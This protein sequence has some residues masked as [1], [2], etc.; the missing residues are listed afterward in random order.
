[1]LYRYNKR[2]VATARRLR[3][4][5]TKEERHLWYDFL[6]KLPITVNRQKNIGDYIVDFFIAEKRIVIELDGAQ[7]GT[8]EG[9]E[10][11]ARR[12]AELSRLGL[13][14]LRYKNADIHQNFKDVCADILKH[15]GMNET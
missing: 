3:K 9:K 6:K 4:D 7:H 11:D 12:D 15:L 8:P 1:M 14:V 5:M 10:S 2:L 13:V